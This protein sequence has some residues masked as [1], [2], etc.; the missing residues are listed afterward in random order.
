MISILDAATND[1]ASLINRLDLEATP[2]SSNGT[3]FRPS[4]LTLSGSPSRALLPRDDS[5]V[6]R[7]LATKQNP[8][9]PQLPQS[10]ASISSLRPYAKAQVGATS[11]TRTIRPKKSLKAA[12]LVGQQIAPW[13]TLNW[14]VS[15]KRPTSKPSTL[16]PKRSMVPVPAVEP[17]IVFHPLKPAKSIISP[18]FS[19]A[20]SAASVSTPPVNSG[21]AP[22]SCTFGSK[23][24][25]KVGVEMMDEDEDEDPAPTPTRVSNRSSSRTRPES[26]GSTVGRTGSVFSLRSMYNAQGIPISPEAMRGL[27]L[28]GTMGSAIELQVDPED[29]D[30]DIPNELQEILAEQSDEENTDLVSLHHSLRPLSPPPV[31]IPLP[32]TPPSRVSQ[33][34]EELHAPIYRAQLDDEEANHGDVDDGASEEDDTK[35]SFDFTGELQRLSQSGVSDRR[36]FVEQLENAFRTPAMID[37]GLDTDFQATDAPPIPAILVDQPH[38]PEDFSPR[39]VSRPQVVTYNSSGEEITQDISFC[40]SSASDTLE[41]ILAEREDDLCRPYPEMRRSNPSMRSKASDGQ[42][43]VDFRFGG[44]FNIPEP[45]PQ[46]AERRPL[47]LS[48]IL[49]PPSHV[50]SEATNHETV[51][52]DSSVL[53][54][55]MAHASQVPQSVARRRLDSFG[56]TKRQSSQFSRMSRYSA[57]SRNTSGSSFN[58]F[59]SFEEVRRGFEFHPN[60]PAFYPP[61]EESRPRNK[62]ASM[63][64]IA[65]VSS[66]GAVF[67]FGKP[68]PFGYAPSRPTSED[69]SMSM[70]MT[71]DDTFSFMKRERRRQRVDSDASSFYYRPGGVSSLLP[72]PS[73]RSRRPLSMLSTVS[74]AL[75]V[76]LY[77]RNYG[78]HRRSDSNSSAG[79]VAQT[80]AMF[81]AHGGRAIW[82]RH[83]QNAS[84]GSIS[85]E[86]SAMRG[87]DRP[88]LGDKMFEMDHGMPLTSITAS[89]TGSFASEF[90]SQPGPSS[91]FYRTTYDSIIDAERPSYPEDPIFSKTGYRSSAYSSDGSVFG[92]DMSDPGQG[93]RMSGVPGFLPPNHFRP[94]SMMSVASAHSAQ[95]DD[96]TMITVSTSPHAIIR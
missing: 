83:R 94:L 56:S 10:K 74:N 22:S 25:S 36:S 27:G 44:K 62:H 47:T 53:Q 41:H 90:L 87:M 33:L 57:H 29:P 59:D 24:S 82:S 76:S 95:R 80:N 1:L 78:C 63:Y 8:P 61:P 43:N 6:K 45:V 69:V 50:F 49:A 65:S 38:S 55:I 46:I 18:I 2:A 16:R 89:P 26:L 15:P 51:E 40:D 48:D 9:V 42:L 77:N 34:L 13:S 79:S 31:D 58:G 3:P 19:Q 71:V 23:R 75:P 20:S 30:S 17:P 4:P 39:S 66:Y 5:P 92:F 88:G 28:A 14:Q 11:A 93:R 54:S 12:D 35:R 60:R 64:S 7:R 73:R 52:E 67:D 85:S 21:K 84:I 68:D 72:E 32:P 37:L 91:Q 96:D 70:S 81:G 86:H